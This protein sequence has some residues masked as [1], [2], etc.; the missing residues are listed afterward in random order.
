MLLFKRVFPAKCFI[1]ALL[2][3]SFMMMIIKYVG[4]E[5]EISCFETNK[6]LSINALMPIKRGCVIL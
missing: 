3:F 6:K 1:P 4:T 2:H 5:N